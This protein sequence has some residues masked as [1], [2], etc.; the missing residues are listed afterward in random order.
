[1][2]APEGR[3][4]TVLVLLLG[5]LF[6]TGGTFLMFTMVATVIGPFS[7][8]SVR[9]PES[10]ARASLILWVPPSLRDVGEFDRDRSLATWRSLVPE[11]ESLTVT[12]S[13]ESIDLQD[14]QGVVVADGRSLSMSEIQALRGFV[15]SGGRVVVWGWIAIWDAEHAWAG[16][17][18]MRRLLGVTE[19]AVLSYERARRLGVGYLGSL[20]LG[21]D[22]KREIGISV[23]VESPGLPAGEAAALRSQG[24]SRAQLR[25]ELYWLD[26]AEREVGAQAAAASSL[27]IGAGQLLWLAMAPPEPTAQAPELARVFRNALSWA[28]R[29]P[30]H[31]IS[32][33][34]FAALETSLDRVSERRITLEVTNV[35]RAPHA[36]AV[37]RIDMNRPVREVVVTNAAVLRKRPSLSLVP[38]REWF[39][40]QLPE[41]PGRAS[42]SYALDVV[43]SD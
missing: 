34:S 14:R 31:G 8:D 42:R 11:E 25:A 24:G 33:D 19:V 21:I 13:L 1:M 39:D 30:I 20:S 41:I 22:P 28:V 32:S 38:G 43:T 16:T 6:L 36:F 18:T 4:Y 12:S 5:V 7:I 23:P 27:Q 29:A 26:A 10:R 40:V 3:T 37:V 35:D 9:P 2:S 17:G 15:R